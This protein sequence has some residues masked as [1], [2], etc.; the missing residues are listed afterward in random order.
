[1]AS[2]LLLI[3]VF[4]FDLIAFGLAVAAEQRRNTVSF[5]ALFFNLN[6]FLFCSL[7]FISQVMWIT[8][9]RCLDLCVLL[10][11]VNR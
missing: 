11:Y 1:M 5:A 2:K 10:L 3:T 8:V 9:C 6:F 4:I 7:K